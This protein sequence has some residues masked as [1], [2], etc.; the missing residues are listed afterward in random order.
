[1]KINLGCT[2]KTT[3]HG[4]GRY[5]REMLLPANMRH[6]HR[7]QYEAFHASANELQAA[8]RAA[9]DTSSWDDVP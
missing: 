7:V 8:K 3:I 9:I 6:E 4:T 5:A 1:M 2:C